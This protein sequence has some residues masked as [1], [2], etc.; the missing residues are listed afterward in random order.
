LDDNLI[1]VT[2]PLSQIIESGYDARN[3][4]VSQTNA[5]LTSQPTPPA[6]VTQFAYDAVDNLL[7]LTDP[8]GNVTR[9]TYDE[10]NQLTVETI[11][12]TAQTSQTRR[13]EYD[14]V[15]NLTKLTDR[16]NRVRTFGYDRLNR[17]TTETWLNSSGGVIQTI[18][19]TYDKAGRLTNITDPNA[20]Y[21]H[22]Y[23]ALNRLTEVN[24]TGTP[25]IPATRLLAT[26]NAVGSRLSLR[27]EI[28]GQVR[29]AVSFGYDA[30]QRLTAV[31]QAGTGITSKRVN[32]AYDALGQMTT[33]SR[34]T[35]DANTPLVFTLFTYGSTGLTTQVQH[36]L[37]AT[38]LSDSAWTHDAAERVMRYASPDGTS[39]YSYD[40]RDQLTVADHS[41]QT[42]EAYSYDATGN[43]TNTGYTTGIYNRLTADGT[44]TFTYDNEGN[45]TQRSHSGEIVTYTWDHR[46]RLTR[47]E[48]RATTGG[49][50]TRWANYTYDAFD[51]RI[52]KTVDPD[53]AS[54]NPAIIQRFVYD[55]DHIWLCF[56]DTNNVT[57]RYLYGPAIDMV[58]VEE[59][60]ATNVLWPL[61]QNL[62][63]VNHINPCNTIIAGI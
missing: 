43:R 60:S 37:G 15:G 52:S 55:R 40:P 24:T 31:A 53:G 42:D 22:T 25:G 20:T 10:L 32:F 27:D 13:Y 34:F 46:N 33:L 61:Y 26:Y 21:A 47:V 19:V 28:A 36:R 29:G 57:H 8:L 18:T 58:L 35:S 62:M 54:P 50:I 11:Q 59:R 63:S 30:L 1:S 39:D 3:R 4:L 51:R 56:S 38:L 48:I 2:D 7:S 5:R 12:L 49:A 44:F 41:Y 17:R 16:N 14:R 23:D 45:R 6:P 9:Y